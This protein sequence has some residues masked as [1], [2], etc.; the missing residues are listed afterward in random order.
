[1]ESTWFKNVIVLALKRLD[2]KKMP[3]EYTA[4]HANLHS[5]RLN[6]PKRPQRR[7]ERDRWRKKLNDKGR[8]ILQASERVYSRFLKF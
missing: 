1:M 4:A 2:R 6:T 8:Q 3:G 7:Q 5:Q